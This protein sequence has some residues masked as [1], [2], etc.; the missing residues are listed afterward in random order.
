MNRLH[1]IASLVQ[2]EFDVD[3][4]DSS[5]MLDRIHVPKPLRLKKRPGI[6]YE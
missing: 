5:L 6:S 3:V 4:G 2:V 1:L